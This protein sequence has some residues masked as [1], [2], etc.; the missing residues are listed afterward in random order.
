MY[1]DGLDLDH[2]CV[3]FPTAHRIEAALVPTLVGTDVTVEALC[4]AMNGDLELCQVS[5]VAIQTGIRLLG[6]VR[7]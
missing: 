6:I 4:H 5:F 2:V 1:T 3:T 7:S